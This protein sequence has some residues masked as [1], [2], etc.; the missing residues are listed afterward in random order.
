M[1]SEEILLKDYKLPSSLIGGIEGSFAII[2][3]LLMIPI[4]NSI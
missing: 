1:L 4:L 3:S 2:T